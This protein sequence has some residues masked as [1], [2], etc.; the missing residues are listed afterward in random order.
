MKSFVF[1]FDDDDDDVDD[2]YK[3]FLKPKQKEKRIIQKF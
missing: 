2:V 3:A 1:M